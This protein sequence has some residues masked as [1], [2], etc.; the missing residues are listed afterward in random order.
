MT[1]DQIIEY[2]INSADRDWKAAQDLASSSNLIQALFF[3]HLVVEKLLKAQW[4]K[5]NHDDFPP[6][7]HNLEFLLSQ[8]SLSML[9]EDIDELRIMSAWNI[10]G[11]YQDYKDMIFRATTKDYV[12]E[13]FKNVNRIREWLLEQLH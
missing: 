6:R 9:L 1:K 7:T 12:A 5:D 13:K 2:W 8:T 4:V 11:R 3:A 10:E